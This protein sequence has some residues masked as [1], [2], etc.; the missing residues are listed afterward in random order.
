[1]QI[2]KKL[3]ENTK[4]RDFIIGDVH[5]AYSL[6]E[7]ALLQI[8][9]DPKQDRLISVGD[10]IDRGPESY[11]CLEFLNKPWFHAVKGN[12]EDMF[13]DMCSPD[14]QLDGV[15]ANFNIKNGMGWVID[16]TIKERIEL[17]NAF[18][19]L[20]TAMEIE[21]QRGLVGVVHADVPENMNWQEFVQKLNE[22]DHRTTQIALW[23]RARVNSNTDS[24]VR[25]ID[26]LFFG[27]T[28]QAN[29]AKKLGNCYYIDTGAVFGLLNLDN[30]YFITATDIMA[31]TTSLAPNASNSIKPQGIITSRPKKPNKPFGKYTS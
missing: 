10:L 11:K 26:R 5:G 3:N 30:R 2:L 4:G 22:Q 19:K 29:G 6:L 21:T 16:L 14:G 23:G 15:K 27:H 7:K 1:M 12:H 20:P 25:G 24:G 17:Y 18:S 31:N 13:L 28:P 9:F 8:N